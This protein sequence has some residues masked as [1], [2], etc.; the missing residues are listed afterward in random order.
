MKL[1]ET[2]EKGGENVPV[3]PDETRSVSADASKNSK[4]DGK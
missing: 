2:E 3:K 4:S 1:M